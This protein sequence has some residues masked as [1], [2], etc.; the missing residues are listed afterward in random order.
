MKGL[1]QFVKGKF[2]LIPDQE[3]AIRNIDEFFQSDKEAFLL[4]GYAGTGK[5]TLLKWVAKFL[6]NQKIRVTLIAPTGRAAQILKEKT[7]FAAETIHKSIYNLKELDEVKYKKG[8]QIHYKYRFKL[9]T[10]ENTDEIFIIDEASLIGDFYSEDDF[11]VFGSGYLLQD[12][13][14]YTASNHSSR[15][16]KLIIVG[17]P[18]QLPPVNDSKSRALDAEILKNDYS[19]LSSEYTLTQIIRQENESDILKLSTFLREQLISSERKRFELPQN[20]KDIKVLKA[21][22]IVSRFLKEY[23]PNLRSSAVIVSYSNKSAYEYNLQVRKKLFRNSFEI[24]PGDILMIQQNNYNFQIDLMNGTLVKVIE[25]GSLIIKKDLFSYDRYGKTCRVEHRFRNLVLA[26]PFEGKT[27]H[28]SCL[29]LE[30]FLNSPKADLS[31]AENTAL[32]LDFKM[33]HPKLKPKTLE[34]TQALQ[35]DPFFNVLKVKY[36]YSITCHKAQ[37]GEWNSVFVNM[38]LAMGK[39]SEMFLRW[40]YTAVTRA[41]RELYLF[42]YSGNSAFSKMKYVSGYIEDSEAIDQISENKESSKVFVLPENIRELEEQYQLSESEDFLKKKFHEILANLNGKNIQILERLERPYQEC[43][44]FERDGELAGLIFYYNKNNTFTKTQV[45]KKSGFQIGFAEE[46]IELF[47]KPISLYLE[48]NSINEIRDKNKD[49]DFT[50]HQEL[51]VLY[52]ELILILSPLKIKIDSVKHNNFQE[53][54]HFRRGKQKAVIQFYYN[55]K[56]EFTDC[57]PV[58]TQSNSNLLLKDLNEKIPLLKSKVYEFI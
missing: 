48:N 33:R 13:L 36:G 1:F 27:V 51:K 14:K 49:F 38:D 18:A 46:L 23:N 5:T 39:H 30:N 47:Q 45:Q 8:N 11:F 2:N 19:V 53:I 57:R 31:Y 4:K 42:N 54:Y 29:V 25:V 10:P 43:Y 40:F 6:K 3:K 24:Q 52:D 32:Y 15:R 20:L 56:Y 22:D 37:G 34:F 28:L 9:Q 17:D 41:R 26:V 12:L 16:T 50:N 44:V 55:K 58:L 7:G 35:R 21:N